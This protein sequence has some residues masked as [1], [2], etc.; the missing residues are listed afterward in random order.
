MINVEGSEHK[1]DIICMASTLKVYN[2][3][4]LFFADCQILQDYLLNVKL[5][6]A[7]Q[8]KMK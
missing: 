6:Q 4:C 7:I 1:N 2:F 3:K 5:L 8:F